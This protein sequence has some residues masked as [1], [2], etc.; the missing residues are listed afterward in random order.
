MICA[1]GPPGA[2]GAAVSVSVLAAGPGVSPGQDPLP[3]PRSRGDLMAQP[4]TLRLVLSGPGR[5]AAPSSSLGAVLPQRPVCGRKGPDAG[6]RARGE[7]GGAGLSST[8][9]GS[10]GWL[11]AA[12]RGGTE[13]FGG[14]PGGPATRPLQCPALSTAPQHICS[15]G[16]QGGGSF[17][18][19]AAGPGVINLPSAL[20]LLLTHTHQSSPGS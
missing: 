2:G 17:Q 13:G 9:P 15:A 6:G 11:G 18:L 3:S 5:E 1:E 20:A 10:L 12:P 14:P 8:L 7:A 19:V 4:R 16:P